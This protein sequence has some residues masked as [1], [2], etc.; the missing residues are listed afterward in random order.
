MGIT[1][2]SKEEKIENIYWCYGSYIEQDGEKKL[3]PLFIGNVLEM[4][5]RQDRDH[6]ENGLDY[7]RTF[8]VDRYIE[9]VYAWDDVNTAL[10]GQPDEAIDIIYSFL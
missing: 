5:R 1:F 8:Y 2:D 3:L 6:K 9:V 7:D 4:L 10:Q